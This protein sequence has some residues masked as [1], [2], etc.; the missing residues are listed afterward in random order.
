MPDPSAPKPPESVAA[1]EADVQPRPCSP[2][3][4]L[5]IEQMLAH[6]LATDKRFAWTRHRIEIERAEAERGDGVPPLLKGW[7]KP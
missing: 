4:G 7:K 3:P 2:E 6:L 1:S 5:T